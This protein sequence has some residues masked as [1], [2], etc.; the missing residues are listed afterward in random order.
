MPFDDRYQEF[1]LSRNP[2]IARS[3]VDEKPR[4][5]VDQGLGSPPPPGSHTLVQVIGDS[6]VG[7]SAHLNVWRSLTPGPYHYIVRTPY[8]SR[9]R[10]PPVAPIVYG[11]EI[12]RMPKLLRHR[13]FRSLSR[14]GATVVIG[15][16]VNLRK[17]GEG[18]GFDVITHRLEPFDEETL[19]TF[20]QRRIAEA[21]VGESPIEL[22]PAEISQIFKTSKGNPGRAE[23]AAH[24][25]IAARVHGFDELG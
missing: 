9:W 3:S 15:T 8:H 1:G 13:W 10:L 22:S 17:L 24:Q 18:A 4:T 21:T 5:F 14:I 25:L 11:D 2:F 20:L 19:A 7:K 16:H 23:V 6:G 12:D